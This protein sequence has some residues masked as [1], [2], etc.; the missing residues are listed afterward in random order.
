MA[1]IQATDPVTDNQPAAEAPGQE[2]SILTGAVKA[3]EAPKAQTDAP[4]AWTAQLE[5][6]LQGDAG[7]TKFKSI[8]ELGKSYK[9]L[10]GKLGKAIVPPGP[11]ATDEDIRAF[12][13]KIGAPDSPDKYTLDTSKLPK[14]LAS[15]ELE[16]SFRAWAH[17]LGLSNKQA[18]TLFDKYNATAMEAFRQREQLIAVKADQTRELLQAEWGANYK[19]NMAHMERAFTK[20]GTPEVAKLITASGLGNDPNVV[21]MFSAIGKEMREGPMIDAVGA[22]VPVKSLA[23]RLYPGMPN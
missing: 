22:D 4:P 17:D 14:E 8:S 9:E 13:Q 5:K 2:G 23:E 7:I 3:P 12:L 1:E 6:D 19:A 16:K 15:A 21:K 11:D 20:F 10:E 18:S